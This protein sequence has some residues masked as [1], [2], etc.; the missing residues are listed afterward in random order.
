M[1][2]KIITSFGSG[3]TKPEEPYYNEVIELGK[4][5][6]ESKPGV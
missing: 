2:N 3:Y 4:A 5:I 6:A 1:A